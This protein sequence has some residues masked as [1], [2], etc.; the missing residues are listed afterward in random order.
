LYVAVAVTETHGVGQTVVQRDDGRKGG[1]VGAV[2]P[3]VE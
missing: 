2:A 3:A 1:Q